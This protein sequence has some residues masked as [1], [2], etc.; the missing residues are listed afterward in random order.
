MTR[1]LL[2]LDGVG[3]APADVE[4]TAERDEE[5]GKWTVRAAAGGKVLFESE[6]ITGGDALPTRVAAK[7]SKKKNAVVISYPAP[8][9]E[10]PERAAAE[11][12]PPPPPPT[13]YGNPTPPQA[14]TTAA[15][16]PPP[17]TD[18]PT[19][20]TWMFRD[21]PAV[22][23][24]TAPP[25][26]GRHAVATHDQTCGTCVFQAEPYV[27]VVSDRHASSVC[28][29]CFGPLAAGPKSPK[30]VCGACGFAS[31]CSADCAGRDSADHEH[32]CT[33]LKA[34]QATGQ[35]AG[36][37]GLR[38]FARVLN[39]RAR[40]PATSFAGVATLDEGTSGSGN[41][42]ERRRF[43]GMAGAVNKLV[44]PASRMDDLGELARVIAKVHNNLHGISNVEG[45]QIGHALYPSASFFN[46]SCWPNCI[47][48][49]CGRELRLHCIDP[50]GVRAGEVLSIAYT[51]VYASAAV[52]QQ[53]LREKKGFECACPRCSSPRDAD[54]ALTAWCPG[55]TPDLR[56]EGRLREDVASALSHYQRANGDADALETCRQ[57]TA[58]ILSRC[59]TT[60]DEHHEL[61]HECRLLLLDV[62]RELGRHKDVVRL[63][64]ALAA[65]HA[66][67][68]PRYHPV[69]ALT[70]LRKATSCSCLGDAS[71][72]A[73]SYR[74]ARDVLVVAYGPGHPEVVKLS[75][76][77]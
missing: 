47:V 58:A 52:R 55:V 59:E 10:A 20:P 34:L 50:D 28:H 63:A 39:R 65:S 43:L 16:P 13:S 64:D 3:A 48:S 46:H 57:R 56:R 70:S 6:P 71:A 35:A 12:P 73:S 22:R 60:F 29:Q 68:L 15:A 54:A 11:E 40:E 32:E 31:Y 42:A 67:L 25:P 41:D 23:L 69:R 75:T 2:S 18:S 19:L 61:V 1:A 74:C 9:E 66:K 26:Y 45:E 51:E 8:D 17:P 27:A 62:C 53:N 33:L 30:V 49:F 37:R 7:V 72:S 36:S 4:V 14:P 5:T 44:P 38:L 21:T 76:H 24:A 77:V